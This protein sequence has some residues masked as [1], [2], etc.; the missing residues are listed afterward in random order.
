[1]GTSRRA[2][3]VAAGASALIGALPMRASAAWPDRPVRLIVPYAAG[4]NVDVVARLLQP[5]LSERLGQPV[6][7]ENRT[8]AGG[9]VGAEAVARARADGT[10]LLMGSNGPLTVNPVVQARL[11]YDPSRDFAA[12]GLAMRVPLAVVVGAAMPAKELAALLALSKERPGEIGVGTAGVA[13]STHLALES[14]NAASGARLL[15]VPY[16]GGGASIQD[17]IAGNV[18]AAFIELST[19][20]P[21]HRDGAARILAVAAARRI[22]AV[23]EVPTMIEAGVPEFLAASY[24]GMLAPSGTPAEAQ[25]A[26]SAALLAALGESALRERF[27]TMGGEA[28]TAEEA[29]PAGFGAFLRAELARARRAAEIAGIK[30]E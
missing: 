8:G 1:M 9:S 17:L 18:P 19:A 24:V 22:A 30:P 29:T 11:P 26:L 21:V 23:P 15:H 13:S 25:R 12:V 6:V 3:T 10:T 27:T 28:A 4:G 14:L 16:R 2:L 5:G 20:L 7:V